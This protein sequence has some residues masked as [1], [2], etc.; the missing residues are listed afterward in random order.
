MTITTAARTTDIHP[1]MPVDARVTTDPPQ[2]VLDS[3][4]FPLNPAEADRLTRLVPALVG[5]APLNE[6]ALAEKEA[7]LVR[8]LYAEGALFDLPISHYSVLTVQFCDYL[9][10]RIG[11]W[12][13]GKPA[14]LW[15]WR[16]VIADGGASISYL[17]GLL[18]ENYHYVRAAAVRQSPLLSRAAS[19]VQFDLVRE[20]V[21]G[22]AH[23]EQ[24]FEESLTRWDVP[25]SRFRDG[26]PLASTSAFVGLQYRLSHRSLLDYLAGSAALE[27]DPEVFA[28]IGDPYQVWEQVYGVSAEI[29]API[30]QHIRDDVLGGHASLFRQVAAD[31]YPESVPMETAVSAL[32]SAR[33]VFNATRLWQ[34][35]M[36]EHYQLGG[37]TPVS[38]G[39]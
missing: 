38:A 6:M 30:R 25:A 14:D 37:G 15:P 24:Y 23:H 36:Y 8:R 18:I 11:R 1:F 33:T 7:A 27:V 10:T 3:M 12:R 29:L 39:L 17:Q 13:T 22:E 20:F 28:R 9:Y 26:V 19:A 21:T 16:Q 2:L 31:A 4:K 34:R 35:D 5:R 32:V